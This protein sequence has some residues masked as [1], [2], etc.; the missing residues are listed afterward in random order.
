MIKLPRKSQQTT[1]VWF[2]MAAIDAVEQRLKIVR[3]W[4]RF[5]G[6]DCDEA[7]LF[8]AMGY[9]LILRLQEAEDGPE[10]ASTD[11]RD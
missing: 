10:S 6:V 8:E 11:R 3:E 2:N 1:P 7:R 4:S 9:D 5:Y